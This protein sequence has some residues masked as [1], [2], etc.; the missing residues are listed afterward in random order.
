MTDKE[1]IVQLERLLESYKSDLADAKEQLVEANERV[2]RAF[3]LYESLARIVEFQS[4]QANINTPMAPIPPALPLPSPLPY[5]LPA[6]QPQPNY[7]GDLTGGNQH[8]N[9]TYGDSSWNGGLVESGQHYDSAT[10]VMTHQDI[11]QLL[12]SIGISKD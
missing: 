8:H 12:G 3:D 10:L 2:D 4:S 5:T 11:N 6:V 7:W 1:R 9:H